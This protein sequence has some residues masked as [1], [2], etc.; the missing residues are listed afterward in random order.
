MIF[1]GGI[2]LMILLTHHYGH[3]REQVCSAHSR[4]Q[5]SGSEHEATTT[6][7]ANDTQSDTA[8]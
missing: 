3:D 6:G 8:F 2:S 1:P 7:E 5:V 4:K